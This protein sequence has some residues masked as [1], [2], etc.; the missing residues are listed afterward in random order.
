MAV[1]FSDADIS[2]MRQALKEARK[3]LGR[4]S[5][6]PCVGAVIV[7]NG[8]V[9][10]RGYHKKAGAPHAEIEALKKAGG[11]ARGATMYVTLEPCNHTGRTGPCSLAVAAGGIKK[12]C[13]G[14][15]DPNPLVAGGGADYL[16]SAGI[17]V[18]HGLLEPACRELNRPFLSSITKGRPWVVMKA[19]LTLDGKITFR[20]NKADAITGSESL[21]QV[22]RL[23]DRCD[24]ILVGSNTVAVDDPSLTAR[25]TGRKTRNPIR[26]I[27]DTNL[28]ISA[29][30]KV[31][32]QNQDGLTWIFCSRAADPDKARVLLDRGISIFEVPVDES[33]RLDLFSVLKK[34]VT[35]QVNSLLVEGGAAV[36]GSFLRAGLAD[37]LLFFYAP[38][39]GGDGG[40]SVIH[41]FA[42]SGAREDSV[43]LK[44][45]KHR[46]LGEDLMISGDLVYPANHR[47]P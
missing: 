13:I 45:I 32:T 24:A 28:V 12:I 17:D 39:I 1:E 5:P 26:V 34:L 23:R 36:H 20:K 30:A 19:G 2:F 4:T 3:G 8:E 43:R 42:V 21:R 38:V 37:H 18:R 41:D 33:G 9:V 44:N 22:H 46:R 6:N 25:L 31:V 10:A 16:R 15:L 40:T 29:G 14:M 47:Q 11:Q 35:Q 27:L 7:K